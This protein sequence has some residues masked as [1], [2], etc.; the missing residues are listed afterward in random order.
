MPS[1]AIASGLNFLAILCAQCV[2]EK[3]SFSKVKSP[4]LPK[5]KEKKEKS[6][7]HTSLDKPAQIGLSGN[8]GGRVNL[9]QRQRLR[10][11]ATK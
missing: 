10:Q 6:T 5:K 1:A 3:H 2:A 8:N 9:G 4:K 11:Q 7:V